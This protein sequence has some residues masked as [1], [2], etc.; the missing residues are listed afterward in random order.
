MKHLTSFALLI[1]LAL[2]WSCDSSTNTGLNDDLRTESLLRTIQSDESLSAELLA[3]EDIYADSVDIDGSFS[4]SSDETDGRFRH[5]RFGRIIDSVATEHTITWLSDDSALVTIQKQ[6]MGKF[7]IAYPDTAADT[8]IRVDKP[9]NISTI[10]YA[11][12]VMENP[13]DS[14]SWIITR[15][16]M[17]AGST[18]NTEP[19]IAR[20]ALETM[21]SQLLYH[22]DD[23]A[24]LQFVSGE[25]LP[26]LSPFQIYRLTCE[27]ADGLD[28]VFVYAEQGINRYFK[29][30]RPMFDFGHRVDVM[31]G[32]GIYSAFITAHPRQRVQHISVSVMPAA[33]LYDPEVPYQLNFWSLPFR[34]QARP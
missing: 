2:L 31:A 26:A 27:V 14:S 16:S 9:F 25:G 24:V 4:K 3:D 13:E 30:R 5:P 8:L 10:R 23:P 19:M 15:R 29:F 1:V 32:D 22:F 18:E 34:S 21:N 33:S 17:L 20:I 28:S 11:E 7:R 12:A 6:L